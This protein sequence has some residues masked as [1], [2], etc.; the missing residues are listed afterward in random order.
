MIRK[1][2]VT[3][4]LAWSGSHGDRAAKQSCTRLL[5]LPLLMKENLMTETNTP[6]VNSQKSRH[7]DSRAPLLALTSME[8]CDELSMCQEIHRP[9]SEGWG[10][11]VNPKLVSGILVSIHLG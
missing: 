4:G 6:I 7:S 3:T 1:V 10:Y 2:H 11:S 8:G 9:I 5:L